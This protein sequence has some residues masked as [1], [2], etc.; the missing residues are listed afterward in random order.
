MPGAMKKDLAPWDRVSSPV[1]NRDVLVLA[2]PGSGY[3]TL[4]AS[5]SDAGLPVYN[6]ADLGGYRADSLHPY[7][8]SISLEQCFY[9]ITTPWDKPSV[10]V[11]YADNF[12]AVA[13]L[14]WAK[15]FRVTVSWTDLQSRILDYRKRKGLSEAETQEKE[16][17]VIAN[18]QSINVLLSRTPFV[19]IQEMPRNPRALLSLLRYSNPEPYFSEVVIQAV[20]TIQDKPGD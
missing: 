19:P 4:I 16:D 5:A 17:A 1:R 11:G 13:S 9:R 6:L 15:V 2:A 18:L 20:R 14:P 8:W 7:S 12:L 10:Y 3:E